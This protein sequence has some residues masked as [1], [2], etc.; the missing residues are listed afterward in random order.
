M[1]AAG[2]I[3]PATTKEQKQQ[4]NM[5]VSPSSRGF[6]NDSRLLAHKRKKPLAHLIFDR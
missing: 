5:P 6:K 3:L 1:F 2:T 4:S